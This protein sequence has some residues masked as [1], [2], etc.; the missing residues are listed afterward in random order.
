[1]G[2]VR[3]NRGGAGRGGA[4]GTKPQQSAPVSQI[5]PYMQI[6]L[7]DFSKVSEQNL[8]AYT[9]LRLKFAERFHPRI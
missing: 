3:E 8:V 4:G 6:R 9:H 7:S 5:R 2:K 1:M